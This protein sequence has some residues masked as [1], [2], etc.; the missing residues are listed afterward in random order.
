MEDG[1]AAAAAAMAQQQQQQQQLMQQQLLMQQIQRQKDAMSRFPSNIDV[2]LRPQS[3]VQHPSLLHHP[4]PLTNPN[5]NS[6][7]QQPNQL[8]PNP[9]PNP[10]PNPSAA[11]AANVNPQHKASL[12]LAYQ[13]AWRVCHPDFKRPFSSLEDACER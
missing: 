8:H 12:Q 1:K 7:P 5:P 10:N 3:Q 13:D 4:R 2:H 9:N 11:L 6:A